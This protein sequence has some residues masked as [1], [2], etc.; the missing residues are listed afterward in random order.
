MRKDVNLFGGV[1]PLV[2]LLS[3]SENKRFLAAATGAIWK[4]AINTVNAQRYDPKSI[5]KVFY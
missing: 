5:I 3:Y 1:E 4:C 2:N